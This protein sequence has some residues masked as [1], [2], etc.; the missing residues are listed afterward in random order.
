MQEL[1]GFPLH[2]IGF[3]VRSLDDSQQAFE[4]FGAQ[5]FH[6]SSDMER[7][8]DFRFAHMG[9]QIM[10]E[11]VSPHDPELPCA[12]TNMVEKQPCTLYHIGLKTYDLRAELKRL[13]GNGFRQVGE[14][15]TTSVYGYET[16]GTFL[17]C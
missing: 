6:E 16:S 10:I 11:L 17:I 5:F 13:K 7:N 3:A 4:L 2:H 8:L 12:V 14:I 15:L 1:N 9:E